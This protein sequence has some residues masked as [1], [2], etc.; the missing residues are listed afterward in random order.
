MKTVKVVAAVIID[1]EKVCICQRKENDTFPLLWE[2]PGGSVEKEETLEEAIR[3][4]IKEE[5]NLDIE[6]IKFLGKFEDTLD[7][8]KIDVHLFLSRIKKGMP[9][10]QECA[11]FRF[12][13]LEELDRFPLAPVDKKI[14][15][16]LQ[17]QRDLLF[18]M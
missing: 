4:E 16:Y 5:L 12:I 13:M 1:S 18:S 8:L 6:P 2:F 11:D 14:A 10:A 17:S 9:S 15:S 7:S 3:R